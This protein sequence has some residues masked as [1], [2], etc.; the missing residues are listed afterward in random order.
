MRNGFSFIYQESE[1]KLYPLGRFLP[2]FLVTAQ[3]SVSW[4]C[5]R[6]QTDTRQLL[7]SALMSAP[8]RGADTFSPS[9]D[10][11]LHL[12]PDAILL[13]MSPSVCF[14]GY[15]ADFMQSGFAL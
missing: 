3:A 14:P 2:L 15:Y 1:F 8:T 10:L 6:G 12:I 11:A 4:R 13:Q 9:S 7:P 5:I